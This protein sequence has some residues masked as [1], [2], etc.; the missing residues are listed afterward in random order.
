M[1]EQKITAMWHVREDVYKTS[2]RIAYLDFLLPLGIAL[3]CQA[4]ASAFTCGAIS[5]ASSNCVLELSLFTMWMLKAI[6][7][8]LS[9]GLAALLR[10][11]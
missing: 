8:L 1:K 6:N 5:Q 4:G 3:S 11:V 2:A 7:F 10:F 9:A